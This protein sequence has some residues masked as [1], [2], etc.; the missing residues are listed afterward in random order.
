METLRQSLDHFGAQHV[1][2]IA[3]DGIGAPLF[4]E[5]L[6]LVFNIFRLLAGEARH[7]EGATE[8]LAGHAVAGLAMGLLV[9]KRLVRKPA[10]FRRFRMRQ[11]RRAPKERP[12]PPAPGIFRQCLS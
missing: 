9:L 4:D 6:E 1:R 11:R 8:A 5:G 2:D 7:R 3:H 12:P 10:A